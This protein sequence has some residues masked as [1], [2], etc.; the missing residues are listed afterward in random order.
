MFMQDLKAGSV[1]WGSPAK[2]INIEK[3]NPGN[4]KKTS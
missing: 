4:N 3:T 1:V 2:P